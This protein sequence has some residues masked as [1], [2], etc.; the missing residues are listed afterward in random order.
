MGIFMIIFGILLILYGF[1]YDKRKGQ[2]D[3]RHAT[4]VYFVSIGIGL[5]T[6]LG[7]INNIFK[8]I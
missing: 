1:W 3:A 7:G 2:L 4:F 6:I 8:W 5:L